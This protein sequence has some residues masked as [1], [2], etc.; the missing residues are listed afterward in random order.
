MSI[1]EFS[2]AQCG[3]A[4]GREACSRKLSKNLFEVCASEFRKVSSNG[5]CNTFTKN[6]LTECQ[7]N[8]K[9]TSGRSSLARNIASS[10]PRP[11]ELLLLDGES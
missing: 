3:S 8:I 7:G 6:K 1:H 4:S 11:T 2:S 9:L 10:W 5:V